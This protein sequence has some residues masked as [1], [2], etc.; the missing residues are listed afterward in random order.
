M[1]FQISSIL[2]IG[3]LLRVRMKIRLFFITLINNKNDYYHQVVI[4]CDGCQEKIKGNR[5]RCLECADMDLC[6]VCYRNE[7]KPQGHTDSHDVID[8]K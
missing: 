5:Y 6:A 7:K 1:K 4:T 3:S 2:D 8:L